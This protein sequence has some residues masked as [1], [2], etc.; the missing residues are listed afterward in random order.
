LR[1]VARRRRRCGVWRWRG[2][3]VTPRAASAGVAGRWRAR[4]QAATQDE[5]P[6]R[7]ARQA[8]RCDGRPHRNRERLHGA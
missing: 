7:R 4:P 3:A 2:A 6:N 8:P 5:G 1:R